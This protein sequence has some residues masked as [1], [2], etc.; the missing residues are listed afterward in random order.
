MA[1]RVLDI[2]M[3]LGTML[4]GFSGAQGETRKDREKSLIPAFQQIAAK[5]LYGGHFVVTDGNNN[6][7][8]RVYLHNV[9]FYYHEEKDGLLKDYIVYHRNPENPEKTPNPIAP[10]PIGSLHTH[11]SGVDITFEDNRRPDDPAYRASALIRAFRVEE[12][13]KST[14][15]SF[16]QEVDNRSTYF[17]NA[18]FMGVD[19]LD[20]GVSVYWHDNEV[21]QSVIPQSTF[22][23]NVGEFEEKIHK[24]GFKYH[25]K[26]ERF[27]QDERLWAFYRQ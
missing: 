3:K 14:G 7:I 11:V 6:V 13:V 16:S 25:V 9:E 5:M 10:F 20:S 22:R 8:R 26:K 12:L 24:K 2:S 1:D 4:S 23:R 21:K 27:K 15:L 19:V 17:Y 18:L